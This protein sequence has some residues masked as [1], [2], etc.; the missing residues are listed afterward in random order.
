MNKL[1]SI[2]TILLCLGSANVRSQPIGWAE[3]ECGILSN[4][5]YHYENY[6][7]FPHGGGY[8]LYHFNTVIYEQQSTLSNFEARELKFI[9]DTTGFLITFAWPITS[10][11]VRKIT[12]NSVQYIGVCPAYDFNSFIVSRHTIYVSS[13]STLPPY[14][15][16]CITRLSDVTVKKVLLYTSLILPDTTMLDTVYGIPICQGLDK[17]HYLYKNSSDTITYTIQFVIDPLVSIT[18]SEEFSISIAPNP[19]S[20]FIHVL[21]FNNIIESITIVNSTLVN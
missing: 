18:E 2:I 5:N 15:Y 14:T 10:L 3:S 8:R 7:V 9:D 19:G 12:N 16:L 17:L 6:T 11:E 1:F 20:D 21:P 13:F 4:P